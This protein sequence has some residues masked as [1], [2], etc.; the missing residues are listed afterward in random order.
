MADWKVSDELDARLRAKL[1][2]DDVSEYVEAVL[3]D[4]LNY[5]EDPACR[6]AVDAQVKQSVS[7]FEHGQGVD[8]RQAIRDIADEFGLDI[9][10]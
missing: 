5:D 7:E 8:A 3:T 4:Q 6:A 2:C 9:Q 1:G 10:R